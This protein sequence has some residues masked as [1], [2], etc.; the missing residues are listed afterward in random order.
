MRL[1]LKA[2][3]TGFILLL[4]AGLSETHAQFNG[5]LEINRY[6]VSADGEEKLEGN[7]NLS[8]SPTRILFSNTEKSLDLMGAM[9]ASSII[10]RH[11]REDFVFI[12]K[13]EGIVLKKQ[14]LLSMISM[15]ENMKGINQGNQQ[16]GESSY[17]FTETS[18][19]KTINGYKA[20][21]WLMESDTPDEVFH[22][23]LTEDLEINWGLL[24]ESW[25]T[26]LTLFSDL[27]FSEWMKNG[28]TPVQVEKYENETLTERVTMENIQERDLPAGHFEVPSGIE[29][30]TFQQLIMKRMNSG[31]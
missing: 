22:V 5:T 21:K 8:L 19:T 12:G 10:I 20:E 3:L 27:P 31:R 25:L 11:D 18:E 30:L 9:D 13:N 4:V 14:E 17:K 7:F 1:P 2:I 24:S 23:W 15:M 28:I 6:R 26:N 29:V 16:G